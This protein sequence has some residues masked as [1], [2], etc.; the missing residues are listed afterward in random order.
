MY[1]IV[2]C[3]SIQLIHREDEMM[4]KPNENRVAELI[5]ICKEIER[6][7]NRLSRALSIADKK[8]VRPKALQIQAEV[9]SA[10]VRRRIR[11]LFARMDRGIEK[12][13]KSP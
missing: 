10:P 9:Q 2:F 4:S 8:E 12:L 6:L 3:G 13:Y 1:I 7:A 5:D 11:T